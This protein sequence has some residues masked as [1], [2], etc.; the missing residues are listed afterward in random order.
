K[1]LLMARNE[2]W[3]CNARQ[4]EGAVTDHGRAFEFQREPLRRLKY[5]PLDPR[6][7]RIEGPVRDMTQIGATRRFADL[8]GISLLVKRMGG[9][10]RWSRCATGRH[11]LELEAL[12]VE[13]TEDGVAPARHAAERCALDDLGHVHGDAGREVQHGRNAG[14][15]ARVAGAAEH[16]DI[17]VRLKSAPE[18]FQSQLCDDVGRRIDVRI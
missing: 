5:G 10:A 17:H 11:A 16:D 14:E 18:R 9:D 15:Y 4:E 12:V 6:A 13:N 3:I 7:P 2:A 1:Y 8:V